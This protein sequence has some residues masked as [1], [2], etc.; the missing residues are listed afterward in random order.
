MQGK[1]FCF[2]ELLLRLSPALEGEWIRTA[3]MPVFIGGAELNVA[4]ALARWQM[5]VQ[6]ATALPDHY[7]SAEICNA[8]REENIDVSSIHFSGNRIGTYYLPQGK[9]LKHGGVIYD[10]AYSSFSELQPGMIDWEKVLEGVSWFHFTAI[11]PA[12]TPNVT[13]V[14]EEA[15]Q[16]CVKKGIH[17]SIDLNYRAKLWQYGAKPV[18]VMPRL[19]KYCDTVM[20]NIWAA[21]SLLGIPVDQDIHLRR[22]NDELLAHSVKTA[23]AIQKAYPKVQSIAHTFRF[24]AGE[25]GISYFATLYQQGEQSVS[26]H[27]TA[28]EIVDKVG[29][30]DCFMAALIYSL[31]NALPPAEV[32]NMAACAAFGKLFEKGDTTRQSIEDIKKAVHE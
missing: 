12:L 9:D 3:N 16:V 23:Q 30:G 17:V 21:E 1:I 2:G 22:N 15:L 31:Y 26:K 25:K 7:L 14:C 8:L 27:L 5:P 4:T 28:E 29:S 18:E 19:L 24:D 11:N 20:G 13:D 32:I 10:R 6:Y